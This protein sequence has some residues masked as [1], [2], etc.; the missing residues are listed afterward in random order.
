MLN[1]IAI[2]KE[3]PALKINH[4]DSKDKTLYFPQDVGSQGPLIILDKNV[5][6][7]TLS[8]LNWSAGQSFSGRIVSPPVLI[9]RGQNTGSVVCLVAAIHG[10]EINGIE[11]VRRVLRSLEP[12]KISGTVI[13]VPIVNI[14][15]FTH[16]SRYLPDRRDLN[17][18]FPGRPDGSSASRIA[19]KFFNQII[20]HCD[21]L[22]DFHTGSLKRDNLPQI[23]A[24]MRN[25]QVRDFINYFDSTTVLHKQG[26]AGI[27]RTA[28]S[29]A[30]IPSVTF[31]LGQPGSLQ[32]ELVESGVKTINAMMANIGVLK[33]LHLQSGTRP[34]YYQSR[35]IRVNSG[36]IMISNQKI[37]SFVQEN[38]LLGHIIN[39]LTNKQ[40]E[41]RAPVKGRILGMALN[42]F[43]LPGYAAFHI[44]IET[45]D[46]AIIN[47]EEINHVDELLDYSDKDTI[48]TDNEYSAEQEEELH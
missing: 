38:S 16:G 39:P 27:L 29:N 4:S 41:I 46:S 23:R 12:S 15:G 48:S 6:P 8:E 25:P 3:S 37:G 26:S 44:A 30:G 13:G 40:I 32:N 2:K 42:Q 34:I 47:A 24:D 7:G 45:E 17:R 35:W 28:A 36:G 14:F 10:D 33:T 9:A 21:Y 19:Y 43:M 1:K 20:T 5:Q 22:V 31:E 11:I 18:Y